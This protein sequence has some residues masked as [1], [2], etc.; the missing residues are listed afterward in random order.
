MNVLKI[1]S[2]YLVANGFDGLYYDGCG[3]VVG[4]LEPCGEIR[5][6]CEPGV[7]RPCDCGGD[8][9]WHIGPKTVEVR[10]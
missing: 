2:D 8:C 6:D 4:D 3:C 5:A 10:R 1:V 7:R 9:D